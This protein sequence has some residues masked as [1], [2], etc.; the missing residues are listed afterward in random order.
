MFVPTVL[1]ADV[2]AFFASVEQRDDPSLRGRPVV[3]GSWVVMAASYEARAFGVR[4]G[5]PTAR[6]LRLCPDA[7]AVRGRHER[8]VEAGRQVFEVFRRAADV[9][10]PGSL[11]E[12]FLEISDDA[13]E[14][15]MDAGAE[16]ARHLR[17][18]VRARVGLPLSVGVARTKVLAKLASRA[19]KPDGMCV[20]PPGRELEFLHPLPVERIWGVGPASAAKLHAHG[21]RTVGQVAALEEDELIYLLGRAAG[22]YVH[23][24]AQN[25]ELRR[26][27]R[28]RGRRSFGAQRALGIRRRTRDVDALAAELAVVVERVAERMRAKGRAG[29]TVTVRM[30]FTDFSRVAR[31]RTLPA[32]TADPATILRA[33]RE[34]LPVAL[35]LGGG[36]PANLVGITMSNLSAA[37][38]EGQ[39]ALPLPLDEDAA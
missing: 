18:E 13:D 7:V 25:R 34:L 26:V 37:E 8:Y 24:V 28:R 2:D 30:R 17:R 29:R 11:E 9:V 38:G 19:A 16:L 27:R 12:A 5:M 21:L 14:D 4:G 15:G 35:A 32:P 1:H 3:V 33:G 20:I 10:E 39:L 23:A 22:R 6:A 36:R 31:S